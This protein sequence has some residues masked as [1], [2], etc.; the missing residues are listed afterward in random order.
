MGQFRRLGCSLDYERERFA[1][2]DDYVRGNGIT[3]MQVIQGCGG[4]DLVRH[5][6]RVHKTRNGIAVNEG[7]LGLIVDG[8]DASGEGIAFF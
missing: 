1:M 6:H 7:G 3:G 2:D 8:N 5:G 4:L